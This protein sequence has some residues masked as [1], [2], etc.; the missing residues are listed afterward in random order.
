M[1][2]CHAVIPVGKGFDKLCLVKPF[3]GLDNR[4][5]LIPFLLS[6]CALFI[7]NCFNYESITASER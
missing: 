6:D 7:P 3:Q 5:I 1:K 2:T 4:P